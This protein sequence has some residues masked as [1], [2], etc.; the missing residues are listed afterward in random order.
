MKRILLLALLLLIGFNS[1]SFAAINRTAT[2]GDYN[3]SGVYR[4]RA[5]TDSS[6]GSGYITFA[7]DTGIVYPYIATATT[8]TTLTAFQTGAIIIFNNGTGVAAH[9]TTYILP[10]ATVGLQYTFTSD[11][12]KAFRVDVTGTDLFAYSTAVAGSAVT[13]TGSALAGDSITVFCGIAGVWS[14]VDKVGTWTV[15]N[16]P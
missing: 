5:D 7:Q 3:A 2:F 8:N 14:I 10:A 4:M 6:T 9:G 15:D 16:N 13:N 12:A 11:V 1:Q